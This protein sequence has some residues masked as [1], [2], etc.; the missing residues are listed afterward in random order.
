MNESTE[1]MTTDDLFVLT[2]KRWE[3]QKDSDYADVVQS[4]RGRRDRKAEAYTSMARTVAE[5]DLPWPTLE[6]YPYDRPNKDEVLVAYWRVE[7]MDAFRTMVRAV[8]RTVGGLT[9]KTNKD[10]SL[11]ATAFSDGV[12]YDVRLT[13]EASPCTQVQVGTEEKT[14]REVETPARYREVVKDVPIYEW[15]CPDSVLDESAEEEAAE[16]VDA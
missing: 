12:G 8:R 15:Q 14:V 1:T 5:H 9:A 10:G 3:W 11:T 2:V 16:A 13:P 4:A 7:D 6:P